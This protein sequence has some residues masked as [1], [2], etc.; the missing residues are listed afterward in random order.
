MSGMLA[1]IFGGE[2]DESP[3]EKTVRVRHELMKQIRNSNLQLRPVNAA[4]VT[5]ENLPAGGQKCTV[6]KKR[7]RCKNKRR[8][9]PKYM[10]D[11]EDSF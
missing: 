1:W 6:T 3:N 7:R 5:P 9:N 11:D 2:I 10:L 8:F 4:N